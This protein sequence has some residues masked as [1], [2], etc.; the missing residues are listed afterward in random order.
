MASV[1]KRLVKPRSFTDI[2]LD[3][4]RGGAARHAFW[5]YAMNAMRTV[6]FAA[7]RP[8][9]SDAEARAVDRLRQDGILVGPADDILSAE[10]QGHLRA[11]RERIAE[12]RASEAV[13]SILESGHNAALGKS[14]LIHLVPF[15]EPQAADSPFLK[16]ALDR[17]LLNIV[18][19]YMGLWPQLHSV[20]AWLNFPTEESAHHSQL[21]HRDPEDLKII[22]VF[23]YLD[24]VGPE[25]GP[26]SFIPR[27]HPFG[28]ASGTKVDHEHKR[29]V[30]DEEMARTF[31][32]ND[33]KI[34]TGPDNTL[35]M[36]DTVGFHRGGKVAEGQRIL[37]TLTYTSGSPQSRRNLRLQGW[38][39]WITEPQQAHALR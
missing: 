2:A 24:D 19:S 23:V 14:Y 4:E 29:R 18:A 39:D 10:G 36:A 3:R 21:W 13:T 22:K 28:S 11:C 17:P 8:A 26:F 33:W 35:I 27:T 37:L 6:R 20:G 7:N 32:E 30:S 12:I 38:P 1:L 15:D 9:L 16:F 34:C 31:P 25:N 5:L